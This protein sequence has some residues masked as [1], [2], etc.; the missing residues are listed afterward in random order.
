MTKAA[1]EGGA[2]IQ[3]VPGE[4]EFK[5]VDDVIA[6]VTSVIFTSTVSRAVSLQMYSQ[7]AFPP[8]YPLNLVG[9]PITDKT[10]LTIDDVLKYVP[11]KQETLRMMSMTRLL[12]CK[13]N[14]RDTLG[15]FKNNFL[16]SPVG[17]AAVRRFREDM[18]TISAS[19]KKKE[20]SPPFSYLDP[21]VIQTSCCF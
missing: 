6:T 20:R 21:D 12:S 11:N 18:A 15:D 1:A 3:G 5:T 4:G 7:C 8:N 13:G 2:G 16:F 19:N 14:L 10:R 9:N 17:K